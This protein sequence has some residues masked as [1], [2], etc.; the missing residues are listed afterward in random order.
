MW[1]KLKLLR[2]KSFR[3][4]VMALVWA[5]VSIPVLILCIYQLRDDYEQRIQ[6]QQNELERQAER[7][8][9]VV[10]QILRQ[11]MSD[12]DRIAS[13]GTVIR[14]LSFPML[15]PLSVAKLQTFLNENQSAANIMSIDHD[16]FP[17]EILPNAALSEN[18]TAYK[19]FMTEVINSPESIRDPRPRLL[20]SNKVSGNVQQII[21]VR[22]ILTANNSI[23]QPFIVT[24]LLFTAISTEK[25]V[26]ELR[27]KTQKS[28]DFLQLLN[29]DQIIY[30]TGYAETGD[31]YKRKVTIS[32]GRDDQ[33]LSLVL[34]S[35]AKGVIKQVLIAYQTQAY[36]VIFFI[37][38]MLLITKLLADKLARPLK[39]LSQLTSNMSN[40]NFDKNESPK[41]DTG[42]VDY[43]EFTEVFYL[44]K[45]MQTTIR[46]QFSQLYEANAHLEEKV[47][48]RTDA[49]E[50]NI[51]LLDK[52]QASLSGLVKYSIEIQQAV[53]LADI[54]LTT[55]SLA[56]KI[57]DQQVGLYL[58][59]GESF[60]GYQ[61]YA[62]LAKPHQQYLT[63]HASELNDYSALLRL[64]KKTKSLQFFAIGS[65]TSSYQGFLVTEKTQ[66]SARTQETI[67]VLCT[68]LSSAI[69]QH[70]LT[71]K[72]NRLAHMDSVTQLPNRH[73]FN[74]V[75]GEKIQAF[76]DS[77]K[78]TNFG[79]FVIDVNGLKT[80]NDNYG[81]QY[82]DEMLQIVSTAIKK[83]AR[84]NEIVARVGGD[85][86]YIIL[87]NADSEAC[88]GF[89]ARLQ[90]VSDSLFM[91]INDQNLP[92]S[93]S[94]GFASTD[95][96]SL[97][98][99][100]ALADERMYFAKK[101]HY[102]KA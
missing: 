99:L 27:L 18:L 100:I 35:P 93:F 64:A 41:I 5:S 73:Y 67:M 86:F 31:I 80:I 42:S 1:G 71:N 96:D 39:I 17:V 13:D 50:K 56:G 30:D 3:L 84:T 68:M 14:S 89:A 63:K 85:E 49:L 8:S 83:I 16:L 22:P 51:S 44:L 82:G 7:G 101:N 25:L 88:K 60:A 23:T 2:I 66:D 76:N 34:G 10:S 72:L 29:Q 4:T 54:S 24:G 46:D 92:I 26:G 97:K 79:V 12:L 55:V 94:F 36:L 15:S 58:L 45:N 19:A 32:L 21:F 59:R 91:N 48:H 37:G 90:H 53:S 69:K 28:Y 11:I 20:L 43:K 65:S 52:Q 74:E 77:N 47:A 75:F 78:K 9:F 57:C 87:E 102:K 62:V 33:S 40:G 95:L 81:H 61:S 38:L 70:N 98:N 6:A